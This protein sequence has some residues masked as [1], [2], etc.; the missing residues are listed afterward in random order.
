[1]TPVVMAGLGPAIPISV[2]PQRSVDRDHRDAA[3]RAGPVMTV[4]YFAGTSSASFNVR[5]ISLSFSIAA[6]VSYTCSM[7]R[8]HNSTCTSECEP[9]SE[10]VVLVWVLCGVS[11]L[12]QPPR[13]TDFPGSPIGAY[14]A[15]DS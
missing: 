15:D 7:R 14:T 11:R 10:C 8:S 9:A 13:S 1:M 4:N 12:R 2:A 3:L 6:K 5:L